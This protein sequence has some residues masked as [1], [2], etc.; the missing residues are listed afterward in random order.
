MCSSPVCYPEIL[1]EY[2]NDFTATQGS[3]EVIINPEG[4]VTSTDGVAMFDAQGTVEYYHMCAN[5]WRGHNMLSFKFHPNDTS[6]G[7]KVGIMTN[8]KRHHVESFKISWCG[9]E[10]SLH[11]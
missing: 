10:V 5:D 6:Q 2:A 1:Y 9:D 3:G 7:E 8:T 11:F 4:S